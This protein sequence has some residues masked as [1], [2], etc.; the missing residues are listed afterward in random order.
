MGFDI[1][2]IHKCIN[3]CQVSMKLFVN[4][5]IRPSFQTSSEGPGYFFM[6]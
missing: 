6:H 1:G 3:N 4:E 5:A 2:I